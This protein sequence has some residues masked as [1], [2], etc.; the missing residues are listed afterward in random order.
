MLPYLGPGRRAQTQPPRPS[1]VGWAVLGLL[2]YSPGLSGYE[3][4]HWA[5]HSLRFF[6]RAPAMSQVYTELQRLEE[7]QWVESW[8]EP[9]DEVRTKRVYRLTEEG[10]DALRSH[11]ESA[12]FQPPVVKNPVAMRV[13]LGHLTDGAGLMTLVDAYSEHLG[14][15][16]DDVQEAVATT[17]GRPELGY[18]TAALHWIERMFQAEA[19]SLVGLRQELAALEHGEGGAAPGPGPSAPR[20]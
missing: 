13:W 16:L 8:D 3:L 11:V 20:P 6:Y 5:D 19:D 7:L 9:Q 14:A 1:A 15:L 17:E 18:A 12:P 10:N 2:S 4:K